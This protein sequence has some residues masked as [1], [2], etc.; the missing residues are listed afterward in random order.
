MIRRPPRSTLFPYTTL[1]RSHVTLP[2]VVPQHDFLVAQR[3]D[4]LRKQRDL[5]AATRGVDHEVRDGQPRGPAP[6]GLNDLEPFLD[7]GTEVLGARDLIAHVDVVGAH[8][9]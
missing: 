8:P 6:Q 4:V 5:A 7:G 1:F 2:R 9:R 3:L